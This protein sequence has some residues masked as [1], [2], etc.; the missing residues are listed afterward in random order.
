MQ[1]IYASYCGCH[2]SHERGPP[3]R[4]HRLIHRRMYTVIAHVDYVILSVR[5]T[6]ALKNERV[7]VDE[8]ET[9]TEIPQGFFPLGMFNDVSSYP[10]DMPP[11]ITG[12]KSRWYRS[13]NEWVWE[14]C[15]I[16][17]EKDEQYHIRF[18][19]SKREKQVLPLNI[20]FDFETPE[21]YEKR[22]E[23]ANAHRVVHEAICKFYARVERVGLDEGDKLSE[24]PIQWI[25]DTK[26]R[27][28]VPQTSD[29]MEQLTA[30]VRACG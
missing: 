5:A 29:V 4:V 18:S 2:A 9:A 13:A 30:E 7:D 25:D 6:T 22:L 23:R 19:S 14:P 10:I 21:M 20:M 28:G 16:L 27:L 24:L 1:V 3:H 17:D 26:K 8:Q 11:Q 12:A 15:E